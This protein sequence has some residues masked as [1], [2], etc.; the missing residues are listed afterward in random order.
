[1]SAS[2]VRPRLVVVL[3]HGIRPVLWTDEVQAILRGFADVH[4][5]DI[6]RDAS[7]ATRNATV[8]AALQD[9]DGLVLCGWYDAGIGYL[10][11]ERLARAPQLRFIGSSA[12]DRNQQFLDLDAALAAGIAMSDTSR[13]MAPWVAEYE[14]GLLLGALRR[15]PQEH[16]IVGAGGWVNYRDVGPEIDRLHGRR[17]GLASFGAI[18]RHLVR[19]LVPFEVSWR[20]YD[21]YVPAEDIRAAGGEPA[22]DLVAMA[23]ASEILCVATPPNA[24]T[25]GTISRDVID[26]LPAGGIVVVASR[27]IVVDQAALVAR[28]ERGELRVATDVYEPEPPGPQDPLRHLPG[29]VHTPHRAGGTIGAHRTVFRET[30]EE[31]R[32]FFAGE[33][34]RYPL[35]PELVRLTG[36]DEALPD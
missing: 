11:A 29:V 12:S 13:A 9:A 2:G 27:L 25:I 36:R 5:V 24:A 4:E 35:R 10:S 6:D 31:A 33:T 15:I 32:R 18:H 3:A 21:P 1:M 14:L 8:D 23:A 19:L 26:A 34:L 22:T 16:A 17:I 20:A 28:T 30:C 7:P